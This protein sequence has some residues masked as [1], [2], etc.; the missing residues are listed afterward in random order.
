MGLL[1]KMFDTVVSGAKVAGELASAI[2]ESGKPV[3][4][5]QEVIKDPIIRD[6]NGI[7]LF[8]GIE[9]LK[10]EKLSNPYGYY[11]RYQ[12]CYKSSNTKNEL[13]PKLLGKLNE[14]FCRNINIKQIKTLYNDTKWMLN[15]CPIK[16]NYLDFDNLETINKNREKLHIYSYQ[17][18]FFDCETF[19]IL[20]ETSCWSGTSDPADFINVTYMKE[21]NIISFG[22]NKLP[23]DSKGESYDFSMDGGLH[24]IFNVDVNNSNGILFYTSRKKIFT[25]LD[26]PIIKEVSNEK[27]SEN[28]KIFID[29]LTNSANQYINDEEDKRLK[30]IEE[31][32]AKE[33][34]EEKEKAIKEENEMLSSLDSL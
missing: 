10:E 28:F 7:I 13:I 22:F 6:A 11:S 31:K 4:E 14:I 23:S 29:K 24:Y 18:I 5:E 30:I 21:G 9:K 26:L 16:P 15:K 1:G 17:R 2:I 20:L 12:K 27:I 8:P 25:F 33:I 32:K 34:A 3:P 19:Q